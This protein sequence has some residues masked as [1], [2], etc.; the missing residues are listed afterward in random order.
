MKRKHIFTYINF[1]VICKFK[2][3]NLNELFNE[4]IFQIVNSWTPKLT[5][6]VRPIIFLKNKK[7]YINLLYFINK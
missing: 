3:F 5:C 2:L 6:P 7:I 4:F 1:I